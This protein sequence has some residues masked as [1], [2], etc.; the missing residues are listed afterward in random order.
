M[1]GC[2]KTVHM[3]WTDV[4]DGTP[5]PTFLVSNYNS[6]SI[7]SS[8]TICLQQKVVP[9]MFLSDLLLQ[10]TGTGSHFITI[11]IFDALC[12]ASRT[13]RRSPLAVL[14]VL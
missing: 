10:A 8:H 11:R 9:K 4:I 13:A 3:R 12:R 6:V 2:P 14:W 7:G 1:I 5:A